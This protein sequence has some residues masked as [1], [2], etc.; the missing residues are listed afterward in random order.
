M[1]SSVLP[2][3]IIPRQP[4]QLT[5][6]LFEVAHNSTLR[7]PKTNGTASI[8]HNGTHVA[9]AAVAAHSLS[10]VPQPWTGCNE[11]LWD[12][13]VVEV[14]VRPFTDRSFGT[15]LE[16]EAN[17]YA[18][19]YAKVVDNP[20]CAR[21]PRVRKCSPGGFTGANNSASTVDGLCHRALDTGCDLIGRTVTFGADS[22]SVE[23]SIP[24]A[25]LHA[26]FGGPPSSSR[27]LL[28][29]FQ[30]DFRAPP[31]SPTSTC[32]N[33]VRVCSLASAG[34]TPAMAQGAFSPEYHVCKGFLAARLEG[35]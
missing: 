34:W 20:S 2:L 1:A 18:G 5:L 29:V 23:I 19:V 33:D 11:H 28:N 6:P 3:L 31:A 9:V 22:W 15:Y 27:L 16:V 32:S 4:S 26:E 7:G 25:L 21:T 13:Q 17:P 8:S 35:L 12:H 24:L 30:N 10:P 14:F